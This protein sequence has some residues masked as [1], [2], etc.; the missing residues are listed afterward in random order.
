MSVAMF[1]SLFLASLP[2]PS[3]ERDYASYDISTESS[4]KQLIPG[5]NLLTD[6][7]RT[8]CA[9]LLSSAFWV[10]EE[11]FMAGYTVEVFPMLTLCAYFAGTVCDDIN[12]AVRVKLLRARVLSKTQLYAEACNHLLDV[13]TGNGI[14]S[15]GEVLN[16]KMNRNGLTFNNTKAVSDEANTIILR[17]LVNLDL[18]PVHFN[19][20]GKALSKEISL[21]HAC[22]LLDISSSL[23]VIPE[24]IKQVTP[25]EAQPS[26]SVVAP[27]E[28]TASRTSHRS[29]NKSTPRDNHSRKSNKSNKS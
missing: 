23:Y 10:T 9:S 19:V 16:N 20:F 2:H 5:V 26:E 8:D 4:M 6:A 22:I 18:S 25:V 24:E 15:H 13:F 7:F 29:K 3:S 28:N 27:A 1:K 11:L 17:N 21:C 14:S 12:M